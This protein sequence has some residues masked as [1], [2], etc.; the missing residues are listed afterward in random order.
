MTVQQC[1]ALIV[2]LFS[3]WLILRWFIGYEMILFLSRPLDIDGHTTLA[4]VNAIIVLAFA[5]LLWRFP[6]GIARKFIP[7]TQFDDTLTTQTRD[8]L[9]AVLIALGMWLLLSRTLPD[10][11]YYLNE[12]TIWK[13]KPFQRPY[14][15]G[16][17]ISG[18]ANLVIV[19]IETV[20]ALALIFKA[21]TVMD[22][23]AGN[24]HADEPSDESSH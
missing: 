23:L 11:A 20:I 16:T 21:E 15:S 8:L 7:K 5:L 4:F 9:R 14:S 2:R 19:I 18:H 10:F 17:I 22:L 24:R 12:L 13:D 1:I 3:A 6:L